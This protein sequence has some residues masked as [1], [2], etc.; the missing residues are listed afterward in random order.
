MT[1]KDND[2]DIDIFIGKL[3]D[4]WY[5]IFYTTGGRNAKPNWSKRYIADEWEEVLGFLENEINLIF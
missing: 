3:S 4:E 2:R 5:C 1:Y